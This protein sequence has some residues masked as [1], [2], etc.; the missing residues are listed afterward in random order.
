MTDTIDE[1]WLQNQPEFEG[2]KFKSVTKGRTDLNEFE[3][4]NKETESKKENQDTDFEP[5][6]SKMKE[7]LKQEVE[8]VILSN[9]LTDSAVCFVV[10]EG[11]VDMQMERVLK[12]QQNYNAPSRRILEVNPDHP[13]LQKLAKAGNAASEDSIWMLFDQAKILQGEPV[14]D[15]AAFTKRLNDLMT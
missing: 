13:L 15:P 7:Q 2:L 12:I 14:K 8:D 9:R 5:L 10:A 11:G 3:P 4:E 1:F 6:L